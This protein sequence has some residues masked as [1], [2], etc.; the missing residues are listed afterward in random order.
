[1]L[2]S[3]TQH[4]AELEQKQNDSEKKK[5]Q[6]EFVKYSSVVQVRRWPQTPVFSVS[7][8]TPFVLTKVVSPAK[9]CP[10]DGLL[11]ILKNNITC[12]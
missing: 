4:A 3:I 12:L 6:G 1:M 10:L 11:H 8:S 7:S 5:L 2:C 9:A